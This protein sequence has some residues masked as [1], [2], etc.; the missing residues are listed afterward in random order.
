MS[1]H[2][3][4]LHSDDCKRSDILSLK[5]GSD[6]RSKPSKGITINIAYLHLLK[7]CT[8]KPSLLLYWITHSQSFELHIGV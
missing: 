6:L 5:I 2:I 1:K 3:T 8:F 4:L 7:V